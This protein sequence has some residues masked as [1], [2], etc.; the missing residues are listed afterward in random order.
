MKKNLNIA[1]EACEVLPAKL[2]EEL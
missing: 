1:R 2:R